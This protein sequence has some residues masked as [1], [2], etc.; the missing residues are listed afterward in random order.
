M[1]T[2]MANKGIVNGNDIAVFTSICM[3]WSGYLSTHIAMMDALDTKEM[4]G[5]AIF[6]HTIGGIGAGIASHLI[7]LLIGG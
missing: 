4:T 5:N 3:C 6:C 7:W 1:V 2:D